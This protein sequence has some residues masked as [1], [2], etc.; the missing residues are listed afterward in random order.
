MRCTYCDKCL[1]VLKPEDIKY[2]VFEVILRESDNEAETMRELI[3][4]IGNNYHNYHIK[5][6][7]LCENC[8]ELF[9]S[10]YDLRKD[11]LERILKKLEK[12]YNKPAKEP[13]RKK[14]RLWGKNEE[15]KN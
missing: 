14:K 5:G 4:K 7:E 11:K 1:G 10:F 2:L 8:K 3:R 12:T 13:K 15:E 6:M 9:D